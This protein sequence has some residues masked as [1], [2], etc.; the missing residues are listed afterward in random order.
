MPSFATGISEI[1][2]A[3]SDLFGAQ[4]STAAANSY[5]QASAI[6]GQ[7]V[8]LEKQATA[9]KETQE[10]RQIYQ[11]I[12]GQQAAVGGAGFAASGSALDLLRSSMS[13]GALTKAMIQEQ[14]GITENAYAEQQGLY[15]GLAGAAK[16]SATGQTVSGITSAVGGLAETGI[17]GDLLSGSAIVGGATG[18]LLDMVGGFLGTA[19]S[20]L[21]WVICS[22]L[23]RQGRLP[24]RWYVAGARRFAQYDEK[25]KRGYYIWAIPAVRHLR[26]HPGSIYSRFLEWTFNHRAEYI[27]AQAGV[28]GARKTLAGLATLAGVH[29]FCWALS[30]T[31]ARQAQDWA[32]LYREP[33]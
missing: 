5:S 4:G 9:I 6:A 24:M 11:T 18:G 27:A 13:Q 23:A 28:R 16:S 29:A 8:Q 14:G 17:V 7:N 22:E 15:A 3:V 2:S 10:A 19:L 12:G 21:S 26:K 25:I 1:G 30:R 31:V 20:I 33:A 32:S